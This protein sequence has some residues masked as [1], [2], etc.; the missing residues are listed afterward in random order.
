MNLDLLASADDV[1][2]HCLL[3][4]LEVNRLRS[5]T[6]VSGTRSSQKFVISTKCIYITEQDSN[7]DISFVNNCRANS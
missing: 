7:D 3:F 2:V 4:S 1:T 5:C 6:A